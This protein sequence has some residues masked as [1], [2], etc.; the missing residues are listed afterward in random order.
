MRFFAAV[1]LNLETIPSATITPATKMPIIM[2][3]T[4]TSIK[5][6]ARGFRGFFKVIFRNIFE[7]KDLREKC[8]LSDA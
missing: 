6:K 3:T 2:I 8:L 4:E 1:I 7:E 5:E